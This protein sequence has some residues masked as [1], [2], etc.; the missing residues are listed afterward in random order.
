M[1]IKNM[2]RGLVIVSLPVVKRLSII[3]KS[4]GASCSQ[5]LK[6]EVPIDI[7]ILGLGP[8]VNTDADAQNEDNL[9]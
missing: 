2:L 4:A 6:P 9:L 8:I 1:A 3:Y 5:I 7:E